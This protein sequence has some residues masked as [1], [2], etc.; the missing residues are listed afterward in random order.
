M[1][2]CNNSNFLSEVNNSLFRSY[3]FKYQYMDM[4]NILPNFD[5]FHLQDKPICCTLF[6]G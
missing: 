6:E 1:E 4:D 5:K 2:D 3:F